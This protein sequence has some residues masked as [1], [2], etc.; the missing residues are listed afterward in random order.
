MNGM[1]GPTS[2]V[3]VTSY[4]ANYDLAWEPIGVVTAVHDVPYV[5]ASTP[6][7]PVERRL[8][9]QLQPPPH[10]ALPTQKRRPRKEYRPFPQSSHDTQDITAEGTFR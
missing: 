6:T 10:G 1:K 5:L 2:A 7:T 4:P 9:R 3:K 8:S